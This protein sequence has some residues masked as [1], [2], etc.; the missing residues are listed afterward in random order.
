MSHDD[1]AD[2]VDGGQPLDPRFI[3]AVDSVEPPP[4]RP[5]FWSELDQQLDAVD[6][7]PGGRLSGRAGRGRDGALQRRHPGAS[8]ARFLVAAAAIVVIAGVVALLA[9]SRTATNDPAGPEPTEPSTLIAEDMAVKV[10]GEPAPGA[11][12]IWRGGF[13]EDEVEFPI[14]GTYEFTVVAKGRFALGGEFGPDLE[15]LVD[16]ITVGSIQP[17]A[18]DRSMA[19]RFTGEVQAG[20]RRVSVSSARLSVPTRPTDDDVGS[21]LLIVDR[22][23]IASADD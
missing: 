9:S 21:P 3:S 6:N 20:S 18:L 17:V 14:D 5:G 2:E 11:W 13:I 15:L 16:S 23:E 19:Y 4:A 10:D 12:M 8:R 22:I 1:G 7:E